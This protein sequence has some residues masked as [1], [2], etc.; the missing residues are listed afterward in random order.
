MAGLDYFVIVCYLA[1]LVYV[2][3]V[4]SKQVKSTEDMFSAGKNIPWWYAGISSYMTMFSAGTFV[5]WGGIA[6]R[7]GLV[8]LMICLVYGF[9]GFI[10]AF[11]VSKR[12][13]AGCYSSPAEFIELRFG[14][15]A[16]QLYTWVISLNRVIGVALAIYSVAVIISSLVPMKGFLANAE[17]NFSVGWAVFIFG[18]VI[19]GYTLVGG[20]WA[21]VLTDVI[22]FIILTAT[23]LIVLPLMVLKAGGVSQIMANMPEGFLS[24]VAEEFSWI[25]LIGWMINNAIHMAGSWEFVQRNLTV[26]KPNDAKQICY[27][28]FYI[29]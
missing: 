2:G 1:L 16:L 3:I 19:V 6:Y 17:G 8:G 29:W 24:P 10:V 20:L 22:Q 26:P 11:V 9:S 18:I 5:I 28:V 13:R 12:W 14:N 15:K 23:I 27:L 4:L 25:F 21:V 7:L